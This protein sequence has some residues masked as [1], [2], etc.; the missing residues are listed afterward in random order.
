MHAETL[1]DQ[2]HEVAVVVVRAGHGVEIVPTRIFNLA[3]DS[4]F[5]KMR[6]CVAT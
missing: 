5:L 6:R 3:H 4:V 1:K 2:A